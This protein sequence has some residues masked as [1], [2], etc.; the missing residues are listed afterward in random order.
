[1]NTLDDAAEDTGDESRVGRREQDVVDGEEPRDPDGTER[2]SDIAGA[3]G[4]ILAG[5]PRDTPGV[6]EE[7]AES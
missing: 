6:D 1:M 2:L 3:V 5:E 4:S 7:A